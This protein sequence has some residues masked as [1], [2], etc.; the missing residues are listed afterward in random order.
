MDGV[1]PPIPLGVIL[2]RVEDEEARVVAHKRKGDDAD[3]REEFYIH[4][5]EGALRLCNGHT[6]IRAGAREG[7]RDDYA[8][9]EDD[10]HEGEEGGLGELREVLDEGKGE[11]EADRDNGKDDT[12]H[13]WICGEVDPP[14]VRHYYCHGVTCVEGGGSGEKGGGGIGSLYTTLDDTQVSRW[15]HMEDKKLSYEDEE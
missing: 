7:P 11:N 8:G 1:S 15:R 5:E 9:D 10:R 6:H 12:L 2:E 13:P 14:P 3:S 4:K